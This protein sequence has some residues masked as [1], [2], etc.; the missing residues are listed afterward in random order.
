MFIL[1]SFF[2]RATWGAVFDQAVRAVIDLIAAICVRATTRT[3]WALP[4]DGVVADSLSLLTIPINEPAITGGRWVD[5]VAG[6]AALGSELLLNGDF[7]TDTEWFKPAGTTISGGAAHAIASSGNLY[8][9]L[10][11]ENGAIYQIKF[12]L[13]GRSAGGV[14]GKV[15]NTQAVAIT[16]D[17]TYTQTVVASSTANAGLILSSYTGDIDNVSVKKITPFWSSVDAGE[18][19]TCWGDS[20]TASDYPSRLSQQLTNISVYNEGLGGDTS[21]QIKTRFDAAASSRKEL[22][23]IWSGRNNFN[24]PTTVKSDIAAMV[25]A[26]GHTNYIVVSVINGEAVSEYKGNVNYNLIVGLNSDLASIYGSRYLDVRSPLV[27]AYDS[28]T[29]Q[30]VIDFGHDIVPS[31][32]RIDNIHLT[33]D[34][35]QMVADMVASKVS[36]MFTVADGVSLTNS[37]SVANAGTN[38]VLHS[39]DLTDASWTKTGTGAVSNNLVGAAG[40]AN[41]GG[42]VSG[43]DIGGSGSINKL[44]G[45]YV[46]TDRYEPSFV[47]KQIDTAGVIEILHPTGT[48]SGRWLIDLSLLSTS[49]ETVDRNHP[50]VTVSVEFVVDGVGQLGLYIR[51]STGTGTLS[52]G[53]FNSQLELGTVSTPQKYTATGTASTDADI[54]TTPTPPVLTPQ[55]GAIEMV[56]DPRALHTS[57]SYMMS[58]F[59]DSA[60]Y[61]S[62]AAISA[63]TQVRITKV[64]AGVPNNA[65]FNYTHVVGTPLRFQAYWDDVLGIGIRVADASADI[66]A[67]SFITDANT[68]D[69]T[70]SASMGIGN[71]DSASL[72]IGEYANNGVPIVY[73]SKEVAGW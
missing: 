3:V 54:N 12:T 58:L 73:A 23:V 34:G 29:P 60:N 46:A 55:S 27:A 31:T 67:V 66:T 65:I 63:G 22:V 17:G 71:Q 14:A 5:T 51:K 13:S 11:V 49:W 70:V 6:G 43:L 64:V 41:T 69:A 62:V 9:S 32:L 33:A 18:R 10:S 57:T 36:S 8:E 53:Y 24:D 37:L 16:A 38:V 28:G 68:D 21:T 26:L 42:T 47:L 15:G 35:Y 48:A 1:S 20:L 19:L 39:N 30:D 40:D 7:D 4:A 61:T 59:T 44:F 50:A 52:V 45:G 2:S 25:A 56:V 72:F